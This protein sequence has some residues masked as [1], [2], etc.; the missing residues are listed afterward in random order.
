VGSAAI[1][2]FRDRHLDPINP[3]KPLVLYC[4]RSLQNGSVH[5]GRRLTRGESHYLCHFRSNAFRPFASVLTGML[6]NR[7]G[8]NV[9][10]AK[11]WLCVAQLYQRA[12]RLQRWNSQRFLE[13]Q[14]FQ[15]SNDF[16]FDARSICPAGR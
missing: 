6:I 4:K 11:I 15:G 8:E 10:Q 13:A 2:E 12:S 3:S 16:S 7:S 5:T 1:A 14:R 9:L